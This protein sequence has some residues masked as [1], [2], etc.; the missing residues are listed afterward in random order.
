MVQL[1][2]GALFGEAALLTGD[3]R[4]ATVQALE[5][6]ELMVLHRS[7]VI[8]AMGEDPRVANACLSM[9]RLRERPRRKLGL[10]IFDGQSA[11]GT[12]FTVLKDPKQGRYFHL[13]VEGRFLW[14][15]LDGVRD[16]RAL[17]IEFL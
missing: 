12:P 5:A 9:L 3:P 4:N 13:S 1:E 2:A 15:R 8:A 11:D 6:S 17:A 10:E 7:T 16:L 14:D